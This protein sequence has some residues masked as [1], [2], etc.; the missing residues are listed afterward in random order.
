MMANFIVTSTKYFGFGKLDGYSK[1]R[2]LRKEEHLAHYP[3]AIQIWPIK[4]LRAK[5]VSPT[6]AGFGISH[7]YVLYHSQQF[8]EQGY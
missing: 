2:E 8:P 4:R 1:E 7:Y 6:A 5:A 3:H